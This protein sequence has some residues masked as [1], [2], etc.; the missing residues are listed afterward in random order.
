LATLG[1]RLRDFDRGGT[2]ASDPFTPAAYR[3]VLTDATGGGGAGRPWPW[4]SIKL[5]GFTFPADPSALRQGTRAMS[6]VDIAALG[7][8]GIENGVQ[9][10]VYVIGPDQKLYSVVIRPLLPDEKA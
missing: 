10:G 5:D 7:I 3:T 6:A 4:P 8:K 1:E 9:S 2:L